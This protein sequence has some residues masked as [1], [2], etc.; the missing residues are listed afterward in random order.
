MY[1][2]YFAHFTFLRQPC[3]SLDNRASFVAA[4]RVQKLHQKLH[5]IQKG[6]P[7]G[8]P[9]LVRSIHPSPLRVQAAA[10]DN[11]DQRRGSRGEISSPLPSCSI[12]TNGV[13]VAPACAVFRRRRSVAPNLD[14]KGSQVGPWPTSSL[15]PT[16]VGRPANRGIFGT[17]EIVMAD[18]E[19][20]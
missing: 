16:Y 9:A 8:R 3:G 1:V 19:Q 12:D 13:R 15:R 10:V 20:S 18:R 7:A 6:W 14:R 4:D 11:L 5:C 2:Q 17:A